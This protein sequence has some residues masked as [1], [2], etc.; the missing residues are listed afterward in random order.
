MF[1]LLTPIFL[2]VVFLFSSCSKKALLND[3]EIQWLKDTKTL[4]VATYG[5]FP[6]YQYIKPDGST[7]GI[8]IDY[9][10]LIEEKI[11]HKFTVVKYT[12]WSQV[13]QDAKDNKI[14]LILEIQKTKE[15]SKYLNFYS[16]LFDSQHVITTRNEDSAG[17]SY[18]NILKKTIVVP[19][20][21]AIASILKH[22][23]PKIDLAFEEGEKNCLIALNEGKYDAYIGPDSNTTYHIQE[24]NLK[25][26]SIAAKTPFKY[27][28]TLAVPKKK[29]MLSHIMDKAVSDISMPERD[30]IFSNWVQ[31]KYFPFYYKLNFWLF[32][33]TFIGTILLTSF[34]FNWLFKKKVKQKTTDLEIALV[35]AEKSSSI[36]TNFIQNIS[37]EIRTPM[38]GI[39]GYSELLKKEKVTPVEQSSYINTI[40]DSGKDLVHIIDNMLEISDL[41][42]EQNIV[43]NELTNVDAVFENI[44]ALFKPKA[45]KKNIELLFKN[46]NKDNELVLIDKLRLTKILKNIISNGVKFTTKGFVV[47]T[48]EKKNDY[49]EIH[50]TDTG[51]GIKKK[52]QATIFDGFLQL[53]KEIA[54]RIGGIGLG[55]TVAKRNALIL[56]GEISF[57]S[58]EKKGSTFFIKLPYKKPISDTIESDNIPIIPEKEKN[59][60]QVLIAED[61]ELNFM[62]VNSILSRFEPYNFLITRAENGQEAVNI[63]KE[64]EHIDLVLMDIRMPVMDGYEATG[65]IKKIRPEIP[66]IAHTAYS[67]DKDVQNALIAGCD[68]VL[69]KPINLKEFKETIL[70]Y[71]N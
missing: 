40:I 50:V 53:E 49:L 21:F 32:L 10:K 47:I 65:I 23:F 35:K 1:K 69:C 62:L 5:H 71:I 63:F 64:N 11:N 6:P 33:S 8:F 52:E 2:L 37:H 30:V 58:E 12:K 59:I 28:P 3:D 17:V 51:S 36:K 60:Y 14:D 27:K 24:S 39:L 68:T 15:R 7:E 16:E 42:T 70:T 26:L 55:L 19:K 13:I 34:Y 67:S 18:T 45:A 57:I 29:E 41:D 48:Y 22:E 61:E 43:K 38:N 25:N 66:V 9:L 46:E 4:K 31:K 44:T 56:G 20:D 54:N